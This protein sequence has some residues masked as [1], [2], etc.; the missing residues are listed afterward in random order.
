MGNL[1][2]LREKKKQQKDS[3]TGKGA[4]IRAGR[5]EKEA[6]RKKGQEIV[7]SGKNRRRR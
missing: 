6:K 1:R 4:Q 2:R 3:P 7:A 5:A